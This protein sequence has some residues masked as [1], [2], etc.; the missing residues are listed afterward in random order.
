MIDDAAAAYENIPLVQEGRR[1]DLIALF[2]S[3][4]DETFCRHQVLP[5]ALD[6]EAF[7]WM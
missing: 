1:E 2:G 4:S 5:Y 3:I 7:E 6:K